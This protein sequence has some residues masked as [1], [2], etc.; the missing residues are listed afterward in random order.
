MDYRIVSN[1]IEFGYEFQGNVLLLVPE[2]KGDVLQTMGVGNASDTV[3][4]PPESSRAGM[5]VGEVYR[6]IER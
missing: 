1:D 5:I 3:L 6:S 2:S 4:A